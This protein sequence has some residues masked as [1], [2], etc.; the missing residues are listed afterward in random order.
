M[1]IVYVSIAIFLA[2]ICY[3]GFSAFKT[4]KASKPAINQLNE[5]IAR[6]QRKVDTIRVETTY[7]TES[8]QEIKEDIDYKKEAIQFT[9]DAGKRTLNTFKKLV[10]IKPLSKASQKKKSR[11]PAY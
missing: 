8:Q 2:A 5:T 7:L 10:K 3:L 1:F 4:L 11:G 6:I 9:T